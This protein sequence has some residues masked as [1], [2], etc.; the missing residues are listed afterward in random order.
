M[1]NDIQV[2]T[3]TLFGALTVLLDEDSKPIFLAKEVAHILE[4]ATTEKLTRRIDTDYLDKYLMPQNGGSAQG[5][6]Y[7]TISEYGLIE[8]V[9][10]SKQVHAKKFRK[11]VIEEIIPTVMKT[12]SYNTKIPTSFR[13]ALLLAADQQLTIEQQKD[14]LDAKQE[15]IEY[16]N[17]V[18]AGVTD[19]IDIATMRTIFNRIVRMGSGSNGD[20]ISNRYR[21]IY[22][23]FKEVHHIDL[24]ARKN[25]ACLKAKKKTLYKSVLDYAEA[26]GHMKDLYKICVKYY[27]TDVKTA[28][29]E[30]IQSSK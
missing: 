12:G 19:D 26:H 1:K 29:R 11:W 13:E 5:R 17:E 16:K 6:H 20:T 22:R 15:V 2:F 21:H 9:M 24:T 23:L 30:M 3:N 18:I 8:A 7:T 14:E 27:E 28:L 25:G 10:G 4:Y